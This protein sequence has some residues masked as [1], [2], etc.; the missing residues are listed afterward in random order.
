M[1]NHPNLLHIPIKY[2]LGKKTDEMLN[3]VE[4]EPNISKID[5]IDQFAEKLLEESK[6]S[7][8]F[9]FISVQEIP[10]NEP[11]IDEEGIEI[12]FTIPVQGKIGLIEYCPKESSSKDPMPDLKHLEISGNNLVYRQKFS[13]Q[14]DM[15]SVKKNLNEKFDG[16]KKT[17][18]KLRSE[19][20][21][22]YNDTETKENV[23]KKIKSKIE[24]EIKRE[25]IKRKFNS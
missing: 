19:I 8:E 24:E 14:T 1:P 12:N 17:M 5:G 15:N 9:P 21:D 13:R 7:F 11:E 16:L 4:Q 22:Y 25:E 3:R 23:I 2:F 18:S 10:Y 6:H 20:D